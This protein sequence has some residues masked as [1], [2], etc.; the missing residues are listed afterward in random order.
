MQRPL[1]SLRL[2]LQ[3]FLAAITLLLTVSLT[4]QAVAETY[5][6]SPN[7][8]NRRSRAEATNRNTPWKTI[9]KAINNSFAGDTVIVLDG[10]YWEHVYFRRSGLPGRPITLK[11]ENKFG[12][13]LVG[14]INGYDRSHL[15]VDGFRVANRRADSPTTKGIAFG[16]CHNLVI[17]DNEV[18]DCR[19]AGIS[20][21]QSDWVLI[22]WNQCHH[23]A[24]YDVGQHSGISIY[25]PQYRGTGDQPY[26]FV[27]RNNTCYSNQNLLDNPN[28]GR[29]TD[30]NGIVMDD[31]KN[32]QEPAGNGVVYRRGA[33]VENNL[34]FLNGGQGIHNYLVAN[35]KVRNNTCYVNMFS[36]DFGGEI[37][38]VSS[39]D[40]EVEN[41]LLVARDT[42][43]AAL[44]YQSSNIKWDYNLISNGPSRTVNH[45]PNTIFANPNFQNFTLRP[46]ASSPAIDA[47]RAFPD[48]FFLDINGQPRNV[49]GQIDIGAAEWLLGVDN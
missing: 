33:L 6:V 37:A 21:D 41:N 1:L 2:V 36:F 38:V 39:E 19:G 44:Q 20:V 16:R 47:G 14:S 48:A 24:F 40:V 13:Y 25:Q 9:T 32:V 22:E 42:R 23:N 35:V 5:Y 31:F 17:R 43:F 4:S 49:D 15:R 3:R 29:P 8:N 46:S 11:S 18:F 45:G 12:A 10:R 27:I 28:W 26:G 7:G 30:G 34:C